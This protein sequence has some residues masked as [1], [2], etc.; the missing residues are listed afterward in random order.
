MRFIT[1][2]LKISCVICF[3]FILLLV[4]PWENQSTP[5][6][7]DRSST[8]PPRGEISIIVRKPIFPF[9]F[10]TLEMWDEKGLW[11]SYAVS[12]GAVSGDKMHEGDMKTPEGTFS[13]RTKGTGKFGFSLGL[14]YPSAAHA[15]RA[16]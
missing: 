8:G 1:R 12:T 2:F 3:I 4:K 14:S 15:Q 5:I 9:F 16:L 13:I 10:G 6:L 11:K 7:I